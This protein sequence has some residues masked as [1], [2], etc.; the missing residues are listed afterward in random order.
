MGETAVYPIELK[1][2]RKPD[3]KASFRDRFTAPDE[4][5]GPPLYRMT[6]GPY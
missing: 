1:E 6:G 5:G 4:K 2:Q 3:G